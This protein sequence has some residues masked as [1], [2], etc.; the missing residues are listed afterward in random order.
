MNVEHVGSGKYSDVFRVTDSAKRPRSV[1]MKVMYYRDDTLRR[2]AD[3]ARRGDLRHARAVKHQDAIA[4]GSEFGRVSRRLI[5]SAVSPHFVMVYCDGD[6]KGFADKLTP[7]LGERMA[8]LSRSQRK[9]ASVCFMEEFDSDMTKYLRTARFSESTLRG[10]IFQV[11]YTLA[12]LQR[13]LPGF[14]HNDLSTNNVLVKKLRRRASAKYALAGVGT[15]YVPDMPAFAA[16]SDYDF[17]HVPGAPGLVNERV[18]GG[19]YR[20]D[21]KPN[22]SYDTH[23]FL[24]SV[25]KCV[26]ARARRYPETLA[27]LRGLGLKVEDR[28][29]AELPY[30][31]PARLLA[32][33]YFEPLRRAA[34]AEYSY[35]A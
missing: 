31:D 22:V 15:F 13:V 2:F 20:V 4:I 28:Q 17:V 3:L 32:G 34:S 18:L 29:D 19:K 25:Y 5:E 30:L 11:L 23:F 14:R 7:V 27:W 9:Y 8:G 10:L 33:K 26:Y 16:L 12:A 21:G 1:M 35:A 24:K 6:V